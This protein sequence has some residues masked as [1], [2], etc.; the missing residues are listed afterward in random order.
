ML[1]VTFHGGSSGINN[2]YAYDTPDGT[3]ATPEALAQPGIGTLS[4]LRA[5]VLAN[6]LLYVANGAKSSSTVLA[7]TLPSS[8]APSSGPL[9]TSPSTLIG[10][11]LNKEG[12]FETSIAHPFGSLSRPRRPATYRIR[13]PTW[14]ARSP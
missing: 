9:F 2:V 5:M 7:Y 8:G 12:H 3:L 10:P 14:S 6:G 1:L 13:T 4:E 11:T